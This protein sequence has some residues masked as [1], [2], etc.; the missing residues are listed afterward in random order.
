MAAETALAYAR[1]RAG[2]L[3]EAQRGV[4]RRRSAGVEDYVP[5]LVGRGVRRRR[6]RR[7]AGALA[8][9][10]PRAQLAPQDAAA[11]PAAGR[12]AAAAHG[13]ALAAARAAAGRGGTSRGRGACYREALEDAPEVAGLRLE[14]AELLLT[15][16]RRAPAPSRC[17]Q[18]D[19]TGDRQVLLRLGE[20]LRRP[21]AVPDR[22]LEAYRRLLARDPRDEEALRSR[23]RGPRPDRAARRCPRSTGAS[24]RAAPSRRADL[25]A[26]SP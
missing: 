10:Q 5:A 13:A 16:R 3:D 6:A 19:P 20:L 9:L 26:L 4:R 23:A 12:D 15:G 14:L 22:A 8:L 1:L 21:A 2:R 25:A 24:A 17:W 7:P 18:A 11:A